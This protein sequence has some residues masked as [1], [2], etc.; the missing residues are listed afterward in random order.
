MTAVPT[1]A[2]YLN[3]SMTEA[4]E[5]KKELDDSCKKLAKEIVL[6]AQESQMVK[7]TVRAGGEDWKDKNWNAHLILKHIMAAGWPVT[8]E[9]SRGNW[10]DL[11]SAKHHFDFSTPPPSQK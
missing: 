10:N 9:N 6:Q 3:K 8:M 2:D 7:T 4:D 11:S 1:Y 5:H